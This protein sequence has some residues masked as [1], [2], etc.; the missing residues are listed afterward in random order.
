MSDD[1]AEFQCADP[2]DFNVLNR[3]EHFNV[4][5]KAVSNLYKDL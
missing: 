5:Y 1:W 2:H 3:F 4:L